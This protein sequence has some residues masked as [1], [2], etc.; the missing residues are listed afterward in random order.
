MHAGRVPQEACNPVIKHSL[1][2]GLIPL[3]SPRSQSAPAP[4]TDNYSIPLHS[5]SGLHNQTNIT[6]T[7][8]EMLQKYKESVMQAGEG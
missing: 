4:Q 6:V 2:L 5:P 7:E 8:P 3:Q 1:W